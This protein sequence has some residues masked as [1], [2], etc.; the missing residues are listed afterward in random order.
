MDS[1]LLRSGSC[2]GSSPAPLHLL[3]LF[4]LWEWK[5]GRRMQR[6][7]DGLSFQ[8]SEVVSLLLAIEGI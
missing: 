5:S 2:L 8:W 7:L 1:C 4:L 6:L 3:L